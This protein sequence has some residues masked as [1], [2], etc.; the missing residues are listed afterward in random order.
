MS[1]EIRIAA[2]RRMR[3][4]LPR[5]ALAELT[6]A[7][8]RDPLGILAAQNASRLPE[9]VP[10]R[11]QRMAENPF[12]FYRGTAAIM[13][14]DLAVGA[15]TGIQVASCGDAH[16]ANFG[17]YASPQRTLVFDLNDF[18]EAGWAPWEW[19]LKRFTAS[20]VIAGEAGA[21]D[22]L[23]IEAACRIAV[24]AYAK[25]LRAAV[26]MSPTQRFFS[27]F[28][29]EAG[30][31]GLD[32]ASREVLEEAIAQAK[33][34]TGEKTVRKLTEQGPDG[35]LRFVMQPPTTTPLDEET[36]ARAHAYFRKYLDSANADVWQL[37]QHYKVADTAR[38][39]VGVGSVGTRCAI[40]LLADD[41]KRSLIMQ[42]KEAGRS[43][44]E[45]YGGVQQPRM[46]TQ[47]VAAHGQ[48]A[49]VV[50]LQRILQGVSDP[51]LGYLQ[52]DGLDLYVRQFRDMKGGIDADTLDDAPFIRYAAA[53]GVT[54]ARAHSQSTNAA[55]VSGYVGGGGRAVG[56]ALYEWSLA[57]A[58]LS[59][60]DYEAFVAQAVDG[61]G[62]P[63]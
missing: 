14:A 5:R 25:T 52:I 30:F 18:D 7:P 22:A 11:T 8:G 12:A 51:L 26:H 37:M 19:D 44:L 16:V 48:G 56:D 1:T 53:C 31:A 34:R 36:A 23:V 58:R 46:I 62:V 32:A 59:R 49:R 40:V 9:Y 38:R 61:V 28:D 50:A 10:L 47:Y 60:G 27:H 35:E 39:I 20:I 13:A 29:A 57:Y 24:R 63:G 42:T 45:E 15:H 2:G 55:L 3:A 33:Q 21:R 17:F 43:V 4:E 41:D 6:I 54:L